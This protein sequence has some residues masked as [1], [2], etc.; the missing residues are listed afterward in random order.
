LSNLVDSA[1]KVPEGF[2]VDGAVGNRTAER[3]LRDGLAV[4][5][6]VGSEE[7]DLKVRDRCELGARLVKRIEKVPGGW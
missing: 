5:L 7:G 6:V 1:H 2:V 3:P 4:H